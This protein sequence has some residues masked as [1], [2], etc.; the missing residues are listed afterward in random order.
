MVNLQHRVWIDVS[1]STW[2]IILPPS[3]SIGNQQKI[4]SLSF[5]YYNTGYKAEI[6]NK[7]NYS[8]RSFIPVQLIQEKG[9]FK[10][11]PSLGIMTTNGANGFRGNKKNFIDIIN[12]GRKSGVF[13]FVF[14]IESLNLKSNT[15]TGY[16]YYPSTKKW[17]AKQLPLPD[18]I[19]N[20]IANRQE[21]EKT[22]VINHINSL[23]EIGVPLFNLK[24]FDK[25]SLNNWIKDSNELKGIIPETTALRPDTLEDFLGKYPII[26]IKPVHGKAGIGFI[27]VDKKADNRYLITYQTKGIAYVKEYNHQNQL[28]ST[29]NSFTA[30]KEYIIQQGIALRRFNGNPFDIRV[31]AQKNSVGV[32]GVTGIGIRV[33]GTGSITTHVPQGG[34]IQSFD[35]VFK[36]AFGPKKGEWKMRIKTLVIKI[37]NQ[38]EKQHNHPLGEL[39]MDLGLD[40]KNKLWFFE[41][42]S[43]PMKFDEPAIRKRSLLRLMQFTQYLFMKTSKEVIS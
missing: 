39:S 11:G 5:G 14:P 34:N 20:R 1:K 13:T 19:Y 38:I 41:A 12:T 2:K 30:G 3:I 21:E 16:L 40:E 24:Y 37:A 9:S 15:V 6:I 7:N 29:V 23:K 17:V 42:N 43:K 10:L 25:L 8:N 26:Y 35:I 33:A 4:L 28:W 22:I 18:V 27:R 31:L 36:Q 32:W